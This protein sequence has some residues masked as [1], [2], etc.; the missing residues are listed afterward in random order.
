MVKEASGGHHSVTA[1]LLT[2]LSTTPL[3]CVSFLSHTHS[4]AYTV[5]THHTHTTPT[6][7]APHTRTLSS[8]A[9][10]V[11]VEATACGVCNWWGGQHE[12]I[13]LE[14]L[15]EVNP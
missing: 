5:N 8:S 15:E 7:H 1:V 12:N 6:P 14:R 9:C 4:P 11:G 2:L 10:G 3:E 13:P